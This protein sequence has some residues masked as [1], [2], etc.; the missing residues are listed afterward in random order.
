MSISTRYHNTVGLKRGMVVSNEPGYYEEGQF[1]I[2]IENLYSIVERQTPNAFNGRAYLGFEPLTHVPIQLSL[3]DRPLLTPAEELWI[4]DYHATVWARV[5]PLLAE[6]CEG[7][8]WLR[9]AT[10]PLEA[11]ADLVA[12]GGSGEG[13]V[14]V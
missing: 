9:E 3:I 4:D 7:W 12:A 13:A 2:R 14:A 5:S 8:R 10:R 11:E 1:G 6:G